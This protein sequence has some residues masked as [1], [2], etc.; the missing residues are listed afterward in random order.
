MVVGGTPIPVHGV[1]SCLFDLN[2]LVVLQVAGEDDFA[3]CHKLMMPIHLMQS[4]MVALIHYLHNENNLSSIS[5]NL[6]LQMLSF[7]VINRQHI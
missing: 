3:V 2:C 4:S 6:I 5:F 7:K 1:G